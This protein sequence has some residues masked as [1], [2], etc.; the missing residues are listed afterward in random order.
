MNI[1]VNSKQSDIPDEINT[2]GKLLDHLQIDRKGTGVAINNNLVLSKN[3]D[4]TFL[5]SDDR[6]L[7]ISATFG[8]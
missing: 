4:T 6:V 8:G 3:W 7:I 1:Y 5:K 2:V